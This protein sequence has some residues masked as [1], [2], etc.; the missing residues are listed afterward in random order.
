MSYLSF[1]RLQFAGQFQADVSTVN[2]DPEHFDS[3]KFQR[4]Y[5]QPGPGATNGWWNP[6]GSGAW[7]FYGC[8][9]QKVYYRDG[10]SCDDPNI[11]PIVGMMINSNEERA[12]GKLVDL[13]TEQQMVS[14]IW[15]FQLKLGGEKAGMGFGG[16]FDVAAFADIWVRYPQGQPDSFFSA[17]YQSIIPLN[18]FFGFKNSRFL[19]ELNAAFPAGQKEKALSIKMMVDGFNDDS[20][21][22]D[23]TFGRV[24]G[25][26]GAYDPD[27]PK[28]FVPGRVL[29]GVPGASP[30]LNTAY[31]LIEGDN[32]L[33]DLG[34][35]LQTTAPGAGPVNIGSLYA[36]IMPAS[37]P[38]VV[39]GEIEYANP[40]WYEASAGI[41]AFKLSSDQLKLAGNNPIAVVQTTAPGQYNP[42]LSET[43]GGQFV[44]AD[45]FVF[46]FN[47]PQK[48]SANF[49]ASSYGKPLAK[50]QI[51]LVQDP[52]QMLGQVKQGP[53][54]GPAH[55]GVPVDKFLF[56]ASI[57]T[58]S[59]GVAELVM[60]AENPGNPREYIDGQLYGIAYQLGTTPPPIG[61]VQ[62]PSQIISALVF[63]GYE[64]P[65]RPNWVEHVQPIFQQ[66]ADLYPVMKSIVDL[67]SYG[68]VIQHLNILG[69]VFNTSE[70]SSNYMPVTRDLSL[71]KLQMIRKWIKNPLYMDLDSVE[72]LFTALQT[73]IEL[74]HSTI[75]PY[76][77][78]L[79]SIKPGMNSEVSALIN[80]VV[81]EE[82]LHM[83][84]VC[85]I[86]ISLGGKPRI[87]HPK[88]VPRYPGS[89]PGGLRNGLTVRLRRCS[90]EQIR[91]C[92][93]SIEEPEEIL[94]ERLKQRAPVID[95]RSA[96]FSESKD[97]T[98]VREE[99]SS[100]TIA[101]F[102]RQIKEALVNLNTAGKLKFGHEKLQVS[103]WSGMGKLYVVKNLQDALDAIDEIVEQGEGAA[104]LNPGDGDK[105][106]AH[107]YKYAEIVEGRQLVRTPKGFSYTGPVIPFDPAGV[108]PMMDDP[109]LFLYAP[110][111]RA[112]LLSE[113]FAQTYQALLNALNKTFNGDPN[114]L[115]EAIGV[116]YSLD[117]LAKKLMQ[118]PSGFDDG[119]MAGPCFQVNF[120][121]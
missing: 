103:Q 63:S 50:Q 49:Y 74:E 90:I 42:L 113:Q 71:P 44:R 115:R 60:K 120:D 13:D 85:N 34:N 18:M 121:A 11:D 61:S 84:L 4:N 29:L 35:S 109:D 99:A 32:L 15:G 53:L 38:T 33:L 3:N 110:G 89:L 69:N 76:L 64:I 105:E 17:F 28:H 21:T 101:W 68:N 48:L 77:C 16:D 98:N 93:M 54:P 65:E 55:V 104:P 83:A 117:L 46:R 31:G 22:T 108:W 2:N 116:M 12:E 94:I 102:Y 41:V 114:Y 8:A 70:S 100:Y 96:R 58:N 27:E 118:T 57:T 79:Y 91:D 5:Q 106:L 1:P 45:Q 36:A 59:K 23:F 30:A 86:L 51:S 119:T 73:A 14:E 9:V 95:H 75:P 25:S 72:D 43:P 6:S 87:G 88:F 10:T 39:I 62:N 81:I 66:Y 19:T 67:S 97:T 107:Y 78:G 26:I 112:R 20:T 111:S 47:P 82:M 80:S 56:P 52:S 37:S 7:R 40:G 24:V 92:F